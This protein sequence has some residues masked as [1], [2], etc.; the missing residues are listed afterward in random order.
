MDKPLTITVNEL[1]K[2]IN[3]AIIESKLPMCFVE[4]IFKE[5]YENVVQISNQIKKNEE[6]EYSN[7]LKSLQQEHDDKNK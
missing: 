7:Y 6:T 4:L 1:K 3:K 2:N 5:I